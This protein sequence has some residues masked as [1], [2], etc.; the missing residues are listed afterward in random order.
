MLGPVSLDELTGHASTPPQAWTLLRRGDVAVVAMDH[1]VE[2]IRLRLSDA[3]V[4]CVERAASHTRDGVDAAVAAAGAPDATESSV[5][6]VIAGAL[7]GAANA[8]SSWGPLVATG[9]RGGIPHSSWVARP[10]S[11]GA[12]F[13]EFAR[14]APPL[15]RS[16][17]AHA[18]T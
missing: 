6:A 9:R 14:R 18:G 1:L 2:R 3:E 13:L 12:T 10:L 16:R 5:A 8:P 11:R 4:R 17:D 15:P 7:L